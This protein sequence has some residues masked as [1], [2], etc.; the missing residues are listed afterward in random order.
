VKNPSEWLIKILNFIDVS[1]E[2]KLI[3]SAVANINKKNIGKG[4]KSLTAEQLIEINKV[5][6]SNL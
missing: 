4:K 6:S 1:Y 2:D 5:L 3:I